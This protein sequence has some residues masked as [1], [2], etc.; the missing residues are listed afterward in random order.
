MD[1]RF[2]VNLEHLGLLWNHLVR[3]YLSLLELPH[4]L[5]LLELLLVLM[6]LQ[7][8]VN[9]GHLDHLWHHLVLQFLLLLELQRVLYYLGLLVNLLVLQFLVNLE[10]LL[11]QLLLETL[12]LL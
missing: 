7:F 9:L 12:L 2:L 11:T 4:V 10:L 6:D 5:L 1:L 3:Q 8:L